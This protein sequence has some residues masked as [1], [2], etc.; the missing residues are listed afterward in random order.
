MVEKEYALALFSISAPILQEEYYTY[1]KTVCNNFDD[2]PDFL[3]ILTAV[4]ISKDKK[5]D[6]IKKVYKDFDENFIYFLY[7]LID[8]SRID[9]LPKIFHE[10]KKLL[11]TKNSLVVVKVTTAKALT[12]S[13]TEKVKKIL[14]NKYKGK[15]IKIKNII[16]PTLIGGIQISALG[17]SIDASLKNSLLELKESL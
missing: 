13:E 7:V 5:K 1:F 4:N 12:I 17:E 6:I 11:R 3:K 2:E 8:N 15:E 14:E 16:D 9:L 10:Y